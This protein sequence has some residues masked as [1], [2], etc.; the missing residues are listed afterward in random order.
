M[1]EVSILFLGSLLGP[2]DDEIFAV[3]IGVCHGL[4]K[5]KGTRKHFLELIFSCGSLCDSLCILLP[6]SYEPPNGLITP[7]IHGVFVIE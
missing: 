7:K 3:K 5:K 2:P 1:R 6:P 4:S